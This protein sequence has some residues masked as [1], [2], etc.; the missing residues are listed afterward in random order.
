MNLKLQLR[1][2]GVVCAEYCRLLKR[3]RAREWAHEDYWDV[4][5]P[6]PWTAL[7]MS[8]LPSNKHFLP[9]EVSSGPGRFMPPKFLVS[10]LHLQASWRFQKCALRRV[11]RSE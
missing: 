8:F 1:A 4:S 11:E 3:P 10:D 5:G 9:L 7:I 6:L 2:F